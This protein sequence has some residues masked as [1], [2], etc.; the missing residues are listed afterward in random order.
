MR[1]HKADQ[2]KK[3][4]T[5]ASAEDSDNAR[6]LAE[7]LRAT[8]NDMPE[9]HQR[10]SRRTAADPF[11]EGL[12]DWL[13]PYAATESPEYP[14]SPAHRDYLRDPG[15]VGKP[16]WQRAVHQIGAQFL[17]CH[18]RATR[19]PAFH[20]TAQRLLYNHARDAAY[21][22]QE[23]GE[24]LSAALPEEGGLALHEFAALLGIT[25]DEV[26]EDVRQGYLPI[27][28]RRVK[29]GHKE[30]TKP[31]KEVWEEIGDGYLSLLWPVPMICHGEWADLTEEVR[32]R[33]KEVCRSGVREWTRW[34]TRRRYVPRRR[35]QSVV[36]IDT[37][38][39]HT[40]AENWMH[41]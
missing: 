31:I 11:G 29:P 38:A 12:D 22:Y 20:A 40:M 21:L 2:A 16:N 10:L 24:A 9:F 8:Q 17:A 6:L 3:T 39:F 34:R 28:R 18:E 26:W 32:R 4:I 23:L 14:M 30:W 7:E 35:G 36:V 19:P 37:K 5:P 1:Q 25:A 13:P 33:V 41:F 15:G 27:A